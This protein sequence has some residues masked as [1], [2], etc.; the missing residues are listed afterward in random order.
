MLTIF[1]M[2]ILNDT[3]RRIMILSCFCF[4]IVISSIFDR[5]VLSEK[6]VHNIVANKF[7]RCL[8][9]IFSRFSFFEYLTVL[10]V[11]LIVEFKF[12]SNKIRIIPFIQTLTPKTTRE[13]RS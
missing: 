3:R 10:V 4:S 7:L 5:N 11:A 12:Y 13:M 6:I 8:L 2:I 1:D 9:F